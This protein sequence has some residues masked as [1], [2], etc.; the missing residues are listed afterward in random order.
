MAINMKGIALGDLIGNLRKGRNH[1]VQGSSYIKKIGICKI[2]KILSWNLHW[3]VQQ[4]REEASISLGTPT[5]GI[6]GM[7]VR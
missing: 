2:L 1:L 3:K 4:S 5:C 7:M 6:H